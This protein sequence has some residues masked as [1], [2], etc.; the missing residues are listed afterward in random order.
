MFRK[1]VPGIML[2]LLLTTLLS[3]FLIKPVMGVAVTSPIGPGMDWSNELRDFVFTVYKGGTF[4]FVFQIQCYTY[5]CEGNV[6]AT[7]WLKAPFEPI[8]VSWNP[9]PP[10]TFVAPGA[11]NV[12]FNWTLPPN[13]HDGLYKVWL[14]VKIGSFSFAVHFYI[15][16]YALPVEIDFEPEYLTVGNDDWIYCYIEPPEPFIIDLGYIGW[17][18]RLFKTVNYTVYDINASTIQLNETILADPSLTEICDIDNDGILDLKIA[19]NKHD[20]INFIFNQN[21]QNTTVI[22]LSVTGQFSDG[23]VFSGV[24]QVEIVLYATVDMVPKVLNLYSRVRYFTTYIELPEGYNVNDIDVSS[25]LLNGTV[26]VDLEAPIVI[27][28]YDNNTIPDLMIKF[29]GTQVKDFV[30]HNINMTK[31]IEEGSLSV[32]LTITGKLYDGIKFQ[33]TDT[34]KVIMPIPRGEGR[35][36]FAI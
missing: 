16:V 18:S 25:I 10:V 15:K 13:L 6:T 34:I 5:G 24:N 22:P 33:G 21:L 9:E 14:W 27:G 7:Y 11:C 1:V 31:L 36:I 4:A 8:V 23:W 29:N 20:L 35:H 28:D 30:L 17:G 12:N 19:F 2:T 32:A 3:T 26:P